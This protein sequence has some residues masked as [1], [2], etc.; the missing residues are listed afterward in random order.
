MFLLSSVWFPERAIVLGTYY[1]AAFGFV[2]AHD[3]AW[4]REY[5]PI[6][7]LFCLSFWRRRD[8]P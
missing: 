5:V 2:V 1:C 8:Q 7:V 3:T 4:D 6:S